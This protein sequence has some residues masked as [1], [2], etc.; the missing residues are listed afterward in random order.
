MLVNDALVELFAGQMGLDADHGGPP[1]R[2]DAS[3][4]TTAPATASIT[5]FYNYKP[6]KAGILTKD[7]PREAE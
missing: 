4:S 6:Y 1:G 3:R 7:G 5:V 2:Q